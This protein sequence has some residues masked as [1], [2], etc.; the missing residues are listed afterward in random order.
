MIN[1]IILAAGHGGGDPGAVAQG[2]TESQETIQIVDRSAAK[3]RQ[4]GVDVVVVPHE[5][6]LVEQIN[7]V[8]A[9][10]KNLNSGLAIEVHK[11]AGGGH[12]SEVW[13]PSHSDTDDD[14]TIE[15]AA[16][17]I[18]RRLALETNQPN[19]GLKFAQNNRFGRLGWTDDTNTYALLIEAGF[20]DSDPIDDAFDDRY[21]AGIAKG[22]MDFLGKTIPESNPIPT[23]AS[24]RR[25][26][27]T[28]TV[29][30]NKIVNVW[31]LGYKNSKDAKTTETIDKGKKR[32]VT[33]VFRHI[34]GAQYF[35]MEGDAGNRTDR[36]DNLR[37]IHCFDVDPQ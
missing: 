9:R 37:G 7:W 36:P 5:L 21:A 28:A 24:Y 19:R 31:D 18:A 35:I 2:S 32:R 27:H 1:K 6:G 14:T 3:L 4:W 29:V 23:M 26:D 30:T 22:V 25:L 8:N 10:Y 20:I 33:G 34:N 13:C 12:G 11:N 16:K 15:D 17:A